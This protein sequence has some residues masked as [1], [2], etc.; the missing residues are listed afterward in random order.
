M[1]GEGRGPRLVGMET[2]NPCA[3]MTDPAW[4][5]P[6]SS[7]PGGGRRLAQTPRPVFV[8]TATGGRWGIGPTGPAALWRL[9]RH[10]G[11]VDAY[12]GY[13]FAPG[14]VLQIVDGVVSWPPGVEPVRRWG[15]G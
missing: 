14:T 5:D 3:Q 7:G 8:L 4:E 11:P 10:H 9:R 6:L 2:D 15:V 12:E 13:E 1:T